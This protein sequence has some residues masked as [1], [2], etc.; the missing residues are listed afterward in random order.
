MLKSTVVAIEY[1]EFH[2]I[3][4]CLASISVYRHLFSSVNVAA[5]TFS[6]TY[7]EIADLILQLT[8]VN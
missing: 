7:S 1:R 8:F 5:F 4:K 6:K 3:R 2:A